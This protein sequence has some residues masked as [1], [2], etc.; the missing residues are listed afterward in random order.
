MID[1]KEIY[2]QRYET[3]RHLDRLRW[4]MMQIGIAAGSIV[5]A[6]G[7]GSNGTPGIWTLGAVGLV[8][9]LTGLAMMRIG[10]GIK[11]N[12]EVLS[13]AGK[14]LGDDQIPV[15][16]SHWGGVAFTIAL[17]MMIFGTA[18]MLMVMLGLFCK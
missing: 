16:S 13:A 17:V 5:L 8:L 4:Q 10:G 18:L 11:T 2:Q 12:A 9:F 3:F 1:P 14:E 15:P 6:F 7:D